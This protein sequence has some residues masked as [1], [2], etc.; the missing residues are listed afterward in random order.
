MHALW[1]LMI[2]GKT[3]SW[4]TFTLFQ[5]IFYC[6][7]GSLLTPPQLQ[8]LL[9]TVL[10]MT[11]LQFHQT[12]FLW[13]TPCPLGDWNPL[14]HLRRV[15][16]VMNLTLCHWNGG[17]VENYLWPKMQVLRTP[18]LREPVYQQ[19][20]ESKALP[21][22]TGPQFKQDTVSSSFKLRFQ[23]PL[24]RVNW[25]AQTRSV[26]SPVCRKSKSNVFGFHPLNGLRGRFQRE[27]AF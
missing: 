10:F 8:Q 22:N 2:L 27:H 5:D 25:E 23:F 6:L 24:G 20:A 14:D 21:V 16:V 3:C 12:P 9:F 15:P 26:V 17:G 18:P 19:A 13:L 4:I 11:S 1:K 7:W